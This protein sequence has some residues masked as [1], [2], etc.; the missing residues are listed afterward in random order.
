MNAKPLIWG[1]ISVHLNTK[2]TTCLKN[3]FR[4]VKKKWCFNLL[5]KSGE[6]CKLP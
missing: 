3:L 1:S 6:P 2:L 5:D 4:K